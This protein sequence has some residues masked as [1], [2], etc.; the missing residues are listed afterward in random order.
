M[1]KITYAGESFLTGS[2]IAHALLDYAQALAQTA[3]SAM[4]PIPTVDERG[5]QSQSEILLGPASQILSTTISTEMAEVEDEALVTRLGHAA[6]RLRQEGPPSPRPQTDDSA[7]AEEWP[8][9]EF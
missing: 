2:A 9:Y 8:E 6:D 5:L 3:S 1:D 7:V 4:V